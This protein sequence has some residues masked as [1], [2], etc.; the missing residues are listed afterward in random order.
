MVAGVI[1]PTPTQWLPVLSHIPASQ[2]RRINALTNGYKKIVD[3]RNLLIHQDIKDANHNR[4][5]SRRPSTKTA[6]MAVEYEFNLTN[7]WTQEWTAQ[8][9]NNMPCITHKPPG[10]DLP[11]KTW[12]TLKR[13]RTQHGRCAY[14]LHKWGNELSPLCD[15]GEIQTIRHITEECTIRSYN[16]RPEDFLMGT[17]KS[18]DY[19]SRLDVRL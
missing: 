8:Q 14:C 6:K 9:N 17:P 15:C 2:L 5:R 7:A 4:F 18:I 13:I 12:S 16:D 19:I 3:N 10:F 1:K 11:R